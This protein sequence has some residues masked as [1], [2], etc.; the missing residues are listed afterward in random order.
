MRSLV[1]FG[2]FFTLFIG[3][4]YAHPIGVKTDMLGREFEDKSYERLL[5]IGSG[6]LR[7]AMYLDLENR[8]VGIE[9]RE[10]NTPNNV[11][12]S[13]KVKALNLQNTL[14][15]IGEG[16]PGKLPNFEAVIKCNPDLIIAS[17]L[18]LSQV[19]LLESKVGVP[20]FVISY[21]KEY[22]GRE[23][24]LR[25]VKE[26]IEKVADIAEVKD[27]GDE[28][29]TFMASQEEKLSTLKLDDKKVYIGG[30]NFKGS[31]GLVSTEAYF[32][33]LLML[34]L[35]N[36]ITSKDGL[37]QI[38]ASEESILR[39][40]PDV[41]FID[42][43]NREKVDSE[44]ASKNELFSYVNAVKNSEIWTT[45]IYNFYSTNVENLYIIAY[46]IAYALGQDID[47]DSKRVQIKR[48]F[49]GEF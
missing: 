5:F 16:G 46:E 21:D 42:E 26:A 25:S 47:L 19:E 30:L 6:S 24:K 7:I 35:E 15:I 33:P 14:P 12:Y 22:D 45:S 23:D 8:V 38:F 48:A 37:N 43:S 36:A 13:E 49:L 41:I 1:K 27:R 11:P 2:L 3:V 34:G 32:P 10:K 4:L 29:L 17:R 39:A 9:I 28:L 44:I 20:V 18:D 31:R 40:N